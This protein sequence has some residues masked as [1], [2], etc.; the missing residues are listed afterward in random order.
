MRLTRINGLK[1]IILFGSVKFAC[2]CLRCVGRNPENSGIA[3]G[4]Q[5]AGW[6]KDRKIQ[7]DEVVPIPFKFAMDPAPGFNK[8]FFLL[9]MEILHLACDIDPCLY[10]V[11]GGQNVAG[12]ARKPSRM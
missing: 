4:S 6:R 7:N 5:A 11:I 2:G 10:R 3:Y 12:T 9:H 8:A 1:S